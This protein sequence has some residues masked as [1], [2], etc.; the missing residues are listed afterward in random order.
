MYRGLA[1]A[2]GLA[3]LHGTTTF[4]PVSRYGHAALAEMLFDLPALDAI[5][6][7]A[8][9]L[10][11]LVATLVLV[12]EAF[13]SAV[14]ALVGAIRRPRLLTTTLGGRDLLTVALAQ[15][16]VLLGDA[17]LSDGRAM[18]LRQPLL[19]ATGL[20]IT[21]V[22]LLSAVWVCPGKRA[23]LSAAQ[24][25]L[26]GFVDAL[27]SLPG[28]SRSGCTIATASWLGLTERR[29]FEVSLLV[30]IPQMVGNTVALGKSALGRGVS[31]GDTLLPAVVG[32][33][34]ALLTG[35]LAG[36]A[37]QVINDRGQIAWFAMW[38]VPLA[39]AT[40]AFSMAWPVR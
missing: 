1:E 34:V 5:E 22:V 21:A 4:L 30:S 2:M 16:P 12:R 8:L 11:A 18:L 36:K 13:A 37:L 14:R 33:A 25:L 38:I 28:I 15:V 23:E 39:V 7:F 3:A 20:L 17:W 6:E 35:V 40:F 32:L 31:S 24:A 27:A 10:G 9:E 19:I 29:C 26:V